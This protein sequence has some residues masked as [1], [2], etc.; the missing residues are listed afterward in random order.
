[1][2]RDRRPAEEVDETLHPKVL[3]QG[4]HLQRELQGKI[5]RVRLDGGVRAMNEVVEALSVVGVERPWGCD[6][7]WPSIV[8]YLLG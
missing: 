1:V 5:L 6:Y 8:A 3:C 2:T 7:P 4:H